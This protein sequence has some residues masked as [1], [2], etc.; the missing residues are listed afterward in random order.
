[1]NSVDKFANA[2]YFAVANHQIFI[3]LWGTT[4]QG[5]YIITLVQHKKARFDSKMHGSTQ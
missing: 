2:R 1:M 4:M 3:H 5:S